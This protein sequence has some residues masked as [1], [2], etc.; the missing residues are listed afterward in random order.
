VLAINELIDLA[1]KRRDKCFFLKVDFEK[2]YD[3]VSWSYLEYMLRRMNFE[4]EDKWI[5][6]MSTCFR[7]NSI[8]V[9][10]NGSLTDKFMAQRGL[11]HGD[12]LVPFLFLIAA[13]G[14]AGLARN[15][16]DIGLLRG[17]KVPDSIQFHMLQFADDTMFMS[18]GSW[19]NI[20]T[21]KAI[22]RSFELVSGLKI[23]FSKS[24]IVGI[25]LDDDFVE[26]ASTFLSCSIGSIPFKFLGIP[27]GAN[28][29]RFTTWQ[30]ILDMFNKK[31][32][33]WGEGHFD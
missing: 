13:E 9:L 4:F 24:S 33:V 18:E 21:V 15:A 1:K 17:V 26:A 23:N 19:E 27:V 30:P 29:R 22:L 16:T 14:L 25:N 11:R 3:S 6:W 5:S 28:P 31:L 10:V 7:S 32:A 8:S 12:P 2:A 20:W